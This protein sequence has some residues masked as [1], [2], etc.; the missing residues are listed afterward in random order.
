MVQTIV[1][2]ISIE[3]VT[4]NVK[5]FRLEKPKDYSFNP[6]QATEVSINTPALKEERRPFTFTCLPEDDHLE[7]TIKIYTDH[8]GVTNAL[9]NLKP[10]D[11][12]IV[13]DVWGV[14]EYKGPGTFIAGGAGV[15]PFIAIFRRLHKDG[16]V[17]GNKLIFSNRTSKDIILKDEFSKILGENFINILTGE[18][19]SNFEHGRINTEY[20]KKNINNFQQHFYICGPDPFV[21]DITKALTELGA[22]TESVVFEK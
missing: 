1:K 7:F 15:T 13:R 4:H 10:G 5:R 9:G 2:I 18:K 22:D 12:I 8:N 14:I 6:G 20:L 11:E 17:N 16:K 21:A 3:P 19:D